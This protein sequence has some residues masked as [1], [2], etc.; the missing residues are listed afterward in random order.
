[1]ALIEFFW[2]NGISGWRRKQPLF[3]KPDFVFRKQR[4]AVFVDGCFWHACP[5]HGTMPKT[6]TEFWV[7]KISKN[8]LRDQLVNETLTKKGWMVLRIWEHELRKKNAPQLLEKLHVA[9]MQPRT[10]SVP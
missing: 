4:V 1:M 10:F 7:A 5:L 8:Q 9:L 6:N 2:N 3:G